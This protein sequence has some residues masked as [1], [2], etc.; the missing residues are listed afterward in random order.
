[1]TDH[2]PLQFI[3][4]KNKA[5]P[6]TAAARIMRW[7]LTLFAYE[8]EIKY[9]NGKLVANADGLSRLPMQDETGITN[10]VY[11]FNVVRDI[12]LDANDIVRNKTGLIIIKS[13]RLYVIRVAKSHK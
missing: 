10:F 11:S 13:F 3:F 9:K 6:A 8:Y 12:P 2:Q 4:S 1:M 7:A 5:I